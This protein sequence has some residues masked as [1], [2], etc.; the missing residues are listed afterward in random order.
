MTTAKTTPP[1]VVPPELARVLR[2]MIKTGGAD[3]LAQALI[4]LEPMLDRML[5]EQEAEK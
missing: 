4:E 5:E 2:A 1:E 3:R